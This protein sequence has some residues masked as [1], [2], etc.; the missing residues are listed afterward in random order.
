MNDDHHHDEDRPSG[1]EAPRPA[2]G[3]DQAPPEHAGAGDAARRSR[4]T[5]GDRAV[6][7]ALAAFDRTVEEGTGSHVGAA[8]EAHR[9]LQARLTSPPAEPPAPGQARPGPPR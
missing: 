6:D 3:L 5:T 8:A 9:A 2:E 7:D 4:P 1:Q